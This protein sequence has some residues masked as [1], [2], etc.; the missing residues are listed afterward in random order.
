MIEYFCIVTVFNLKVVLDAMG[1]G[2]HEGGQRGRRGYRLL[3]AWCWRSNARIEGSMQE[4][5][6]AHGFSRDASRWVEG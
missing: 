4:D 5:P 2:G 3:L 1:S 6:V